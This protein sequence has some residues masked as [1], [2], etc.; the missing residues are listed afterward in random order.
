MATIA[1]EDRNGKI[2]VG[3][4]FSR[5]FETIQH[6]AIL[7][8]GIALLVG[9]VPHALV[10]Y[11]FSVFVPNATDAAFV[12]TQRGAA[13]T[14]CIFFVELLIGAI[15]QASI[16]HAT[17]AHLYGRR[18][19]FGECL[20]AAAD[21]LV[22]LVALSVLYT[23]GLVIGFVFLIVP[24]LM[25][26]CMWF[27]AKPVLV[28]ERTGITRA[29]KR[30]KEL[31]AF[32][33]WKMLGILLVLLAAGVIGSLLARLIG[34]SIEGTDPAATLPL[35]YL[36]LLIPVS[37]LSYV[38][39]PTLQAAAYIELRSAKEGPVRSHLEQVFA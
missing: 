16:I 19:P 1:A 4:V 21:V 33:G 37:T 3:R 9:A 10:T 31:T 22:P 24:G 12:L 36:L 6:N 18:A 30:S 14:A 17:I 35:S 5:A 23:L 34:Q 7:V 38:L 39:W 13:A 25:A 11:V 28:A 15:V 26:W 8:I 27:V 2:S 29:F 20:G 32:E